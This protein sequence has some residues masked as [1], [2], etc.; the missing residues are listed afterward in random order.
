[1]CDTIPCDKSFVVS[2]GVEKETAGKK[3]LP[4]V[5]WEQWPVANTEASGK[6]VGLNLSY[7]S[8]IRPMS[9]T[10]ENQNLERMESSSQ[11]SDPNPIKQT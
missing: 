10:E 5:L 6:P 9:T 4:E 8:D 7:L 2:M 11:R 3:N 1:M